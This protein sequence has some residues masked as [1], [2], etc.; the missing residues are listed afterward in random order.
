MV[1]DTQIHAQQDSKLVAKVFAVLSA[2]II[3]IGLIVLYFLQ[4]QT[5]WFY[6]AAAVFVLL[7][8]VSLFVTYTVWALGY[9][10]WRF[11]KD[12]LPNQY[13]MDCCTNYKHG[14]AC[15]LLGAEYT[16][17]AKR[18]YRR[19]LRGEHPNAKI[20][21]DWISDG[22]EVLQLDVED[23]YLL[24][25]DDPKM[26][27]WR[28]GEGR[29]SEAAHRTVAVAS[30]YAAQEKNDAVNEGKPQRS[31]HE[32]RTYA[33]AELLGS[34]V[35]DLER[36]I[37]RVGILHNQIDENGIPLPQ[38]YV[39]IAGSCGQGWHSLNYVGLRERYTVLIDL[40]V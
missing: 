27:G 7:S 29:L 17:L 12:D 30:E 24:E 14:L 35:A 8:A 13:L 34:K 16:D 22:K 1:T 40:I 28:E 36:S 19:A 26:K 10:E 20:F 3:I 9:S 33:D 21:L 6:L 5:F 38:S 39:G 2:V 31:W 23:A 37:S 32:I 18:Y 4:N 15:H 11:N 25:Q